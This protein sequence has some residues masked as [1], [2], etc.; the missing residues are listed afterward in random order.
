MDSN[1][2][3]NMRLTVPLLG[4]ADMED[5]LRFYMEGLGFTMTKQWTPR[6]KI[7]WCWLTTL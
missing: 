2:K 3:S 4:V 7:E 5:S 1:S 6:G